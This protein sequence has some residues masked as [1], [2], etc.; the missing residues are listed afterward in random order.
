M[1]EFIDKLIERLEEEN[2]NDIQII[3]SGIL[4]KYGFPKESI[5]QDEIWDAL[6]ELSTNKVVIS[7]INEFAE[8]YAKTPTPNHPIPIDTQQYIAELE[9]KVK[10]KDWIPCSERYPDTD[11]YILL[12]FENFSIPLVGRYEE[13][14]D[15]GG[16][17]Y[18]GDEEESC[19][20]QGIIVNG[21]MPLMKCYREKGD[22]EYEQPKES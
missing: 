20:S 17:F 5:V 16:A 6:D 21:W 22:E 10:E 15:G 8:E 1:K 14:V 18:V 9:R 11:N 2:F 13:D 12:S 19:I 7:I 3:V 4:E